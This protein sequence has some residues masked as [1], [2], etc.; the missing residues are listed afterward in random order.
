MNGYSGQGNIEGDVPVVGSARADSGG[1]GFSI[2]IDDKIS[3]NILVGLAGGHDWL[4]FNVP[5]RE[6]TGGVEAWHIGG[7]GALRQNQFYITSTLAYDHFDN[8]ENRY[9][10]IPGVSLGSPS[11]SLIAINGFSEYL[12]GEFQSSSLSGDFE[13]GY[14][15]PVGRIE[16]TPFAGLQ[17]G[18]MHLNS[19]TETDTGGAASQIG[20]SYDG[21]NINSL[22]SRVGLQVKAKTELAPG[23]EL[24]VVAR[25]AWMHEFYTDR[26]T[27]S[28][29]IA[30][31]G[32][33]FTIQGAQPP[34]DSLLSNIGVTLNL[35]NRWML[36]GNFDCDSSSVAHSYSGMGGLSFTW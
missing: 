30:A 10:A 19:F 7:Y 28:A 3:P 25:A 24:T 9:A 13:T 17:Y 15:I 6:T 5:D 21:R 8:T 22:P 1:N 2:G 32:Y 4:S 34:V 16:V 14:R 20:L 33:N 18:V 26:S 36:F 29:F 23:M 12:T 27:E 31:P 35:G 11:G